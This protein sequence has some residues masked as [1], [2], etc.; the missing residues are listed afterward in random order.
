MLS[1]R[2]ASNDDAGL[3]EFAGFELKLPP[4]PAMLP[5]LHP[6]VARFAAAPVAGLPKGEFLDCWDENAPD[7][8]FDIAFPCRESPEDPFEKLPRRLLPPRHLPPLLE[9]PR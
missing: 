4:R 2:L 9:R 6:P 8:A 5:E 3:Y 1:G 7:R